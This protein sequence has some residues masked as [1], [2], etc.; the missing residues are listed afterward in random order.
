MTKP[1]A[2][3]N[4]EINESIKNTYFLETSDESLKVLYQI[5][6]QINASLEYAKK[7]KERP[8]QEDKTP[9]EQTKIDL[10][11]SLIRYMAFVRLERRVLIHTEELLKKEQRKMDK[12]KD[13]YQKIPV[14][15]L[16]ENTNSFFKKK[17]PLENEPFSVFCGNIVTK[18]KKHLEPGAYFCLKKK[19]NEYILVMAAY[20]INPDKWVVYDAIP[21][22]NTI[23]SYSVN[24]D[25]LYP[26][27]KSLPANFGTERDF[28]LNDRVL[29]L[30]REDETF[31]WTTQFYV[32]TIIELPKQ[33]GDGYLI[34]YDEDGSESV[35]FEQ[36]V[37]PLD[38]F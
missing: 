18:M 2:Q 29:S 30:W 21:M 23:T 27:P 6:K 31:E 14:K 25:Y 13:S 34:H 12:L 26:L 8:L 15:K 3:V 1:I 28:Q 20:P 24:I 10:N 9:D 4:D 5:R 33:R 35:V 38:A 16:M 36:F 32:G 37:I 11:N 22:N 17:I 7:L 19:C